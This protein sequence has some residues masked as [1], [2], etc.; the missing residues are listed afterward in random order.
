MKKINKKIK[1]AI[2][3]DAIYPYNKGGKEKR[4]YEI[5]TRLAKR[6]YDVTI[7]CMKWWGGKKISSNNIR[8]ENGV[9]LHAISN[10]YPL[11]SGPRRSFKQAILFSISTLKLIREDFDIVDADHMPHLVLFPLKAICLLKRKKLFATWNEVWGRKYWKEY[12]GKLGNIAY[13][14]EWLSVRMPDEIISVSEHTARKLKK[15]LKVKQLIHTIP[16]GINYDEINEIEPSTQKS[17]I[18]YAGRLLEHK[19]VDLIIKSISFLKTNF[20][21]IRCLIVGNGPEEKNLKELVRKNGLQGNVIFLDFLQDH[22]DL[23]SLIKSS[24]VFAF[25]STREGFG[26]AALEAN[27][28]GIPFVTSNHENNAAKNLIGEEKNGES[29]KLE[30]TDFSNKMLQL[31]K[32]S[33][34]VNKG[35]YTEYAQN[36]DWNNITN[37]IEEVYSL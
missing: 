31:M 16:L 6:G 18:I 1:I 30:I 19:N 23:Y 29:A 13:I 4:V 34:K 2:V 37:I 33:Q 5:S 24:K 20:I 27:A 32:P 8:I 22:K 9:K 11:Y 15:E 21:N 12:L 25:P 17:D 36:Y 7:Y 26:L 35:K 3:S 10:Y 28:C 14:I